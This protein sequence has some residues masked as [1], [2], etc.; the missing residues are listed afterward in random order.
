LWHGELVYQDAGIN[1]GN[2][3]SG[4]KILVTQA[5]QE[6][7]DYVIAH[8]GAEN[9]NVP[10]FSDD[11]YGYFQMQNY[12][13]KSFG[14]DV[15]FGWMENVWSVGSSDWVHTQ[16]TSKEQ[17]KNQI[18]SQVA[19]F[20]KKTKVYN[21]LWRPDFIV[22][23][24]YERDGFSSAGRISYAWNHNDWD[25]YITYT[26]D[27]A[28][29]LN[30]PLVLWQIPGGH[31][32]TKT[33]NIVNFD[34]QEHGASAAPYIFGDS[35]ISSIDDLRDDF[36]SLELGAGDSVRQNQIYGGNAE[37]GGY[38]RERPYDWRQSQLQRLVDDGV[39]LILWGGGN[40]TSVVQL[41]ASTGDDDDYLLNKVNDY[42]DNPIRLK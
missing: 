23:D 5:L 28:N 31:M 32:P 2:S 21:G 13:I 18:S 38:L 20:L 19:D 35:R 6:A 36:L 8:D 29:R 3:T 34:I 14:P 10:T 33:E 17:V 37:L 24:K 27:V 16:R 30:T 39:S 41:D 7:V 25:N 1:E 12:I 42:Y 4:R 9:I 15:V 11:L 40:T 22:F 26:G